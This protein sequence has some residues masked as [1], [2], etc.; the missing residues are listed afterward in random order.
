[1]GRPGTQHTLGWRKGP[2]QGGSWELGWELGSG[3]G[4]WPGCFLLG[5][6]SNIPTA[7]EQSCSGQLVSLT[8]NP[9]HCNN[10]DPIFL[11]FPDLSLFNN[12]VNNS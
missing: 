7:V 2:G 9:I 4:A 6:L 5:A 1:M 8:G 10:T 12:S 3:S 11:C